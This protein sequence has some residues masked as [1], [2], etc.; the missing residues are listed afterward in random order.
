MTLTISIPPEVDAR[1]RERAQVLGRDVAEY[2]A[3]LIQQGISTASL[4]EVLDPVRR[5]FAESGMS[6]D[7]LAEL[8]EQEKHAMRREKD[9]SGERS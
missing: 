2:A 7:D 8:L 1:L 4:D 9:G 5:A 3:D 6:D